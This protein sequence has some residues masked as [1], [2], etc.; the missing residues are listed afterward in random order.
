MSGDVFALLSVLPRVGALSAGD[1]RKLADRAVL[2]EAP[3]GRILFREGEPSDAAWLV[4][5]GRV[6]LSL[7]TP[8]RPETVVL[9]IGP[10]EL[11]G[12]SALLAGPAPRRVATG[13]VTAPAV[14]LR[15]PRDEIL[16]LCDRDHDIGY[17]LFRLAFAEVSERLHDTR[18]QLL[19][20][21]R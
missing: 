21:Y 11:L 1:R 10:G 5:A 18:L 16:A 15:L 7:R 17:T 20:L 14:L 9:S 8:G 19:D 12:W 3:T 6:S 2:E 4:S 13:A